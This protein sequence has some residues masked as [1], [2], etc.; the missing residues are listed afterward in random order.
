MATTVEMN[1]IILVVLEAIRNSRIPKLFEI[2]GF[3]L[4]IIGAFVMILSEQAEKFIKKVKSLFRGNEGEP[5][6]R[7]NTNTK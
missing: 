3:L 4:V 1:N 2:I 7:E 6:Q 5:E